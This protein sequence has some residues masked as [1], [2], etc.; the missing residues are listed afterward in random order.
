MPRVATGN[1]YQKGDH[2]YARLTLDATTRPK[3]PLSTCATK[4]AADARGTL[5][6]DMAKNLRGANVPVDVARTFLLR[7]GDVAE[8][9]DLDKVRRTIEAVCN[10]DAGPKASKPVTFRDVG[11]LWT[12][13]ELAKRYPDHVKVKVNAADDRQLLDRHVYPL[14]EGVTIEGFTLDHADR[15][16]RVLPH[17]EPATRRGYALLIHRIVGLAVFPL[18]AIPANPLPHGWLPSRG[19][20]KARAYLYPDE[21]AS[22]SRARGCRSAGAS[23]TGS[24]RVRA[25]ARTRRPRPSRSPTWILSAE[26]SSWTRTRPTTRAGGRSIPVSCG[27]CARGSRCARTPRARPSRLPIGCSWTK[28]GGRSSTPTTT[29]ITSGRT[30]WPRR[31][32]G[33][34]SSSAAPHAF[35]SACTTFARPSSRST[36]PT[37]RARRGS[38]IA[39]GTSRVRRS[40]TTAGT[41][42]P[43]RS[44]TLEPSTP[45]TWRSRSLARGAGTGGRN[46]PRGVRQAARPLATG[47]SRAVRGVE[48]PGDRWVRFRWLWAH[49][50]AGETP[51]LHTLGSP[52]PAVETRA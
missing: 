1:T 50:S 30:S 22:S 11:E 17:T 16:M 25:A 41:R 42:G 26:R 40:R 39:A 47:A 45:S 12:S 21:T 10:K 32:T 49:P 15:I 27:R 14:V 18:R 46:R 51:A 23:S 52:D 43:W 28:T 3:I 34:R 5:L 13:G 4:E 36:W 44:L 19:K 20:P 29:R 7:A 6:A 37:A 31:S 33:P 35:G 38:R 2:W 24:S 8:G 9:T 48:T